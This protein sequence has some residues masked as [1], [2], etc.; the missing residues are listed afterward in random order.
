MLNLNIENSI[1]NHK[2]FPEN[3][4]SILEGMN[5]EERL[6]WLK[7]K[8]ESFIKSLLDNWIYNNNVSEKENNSDSIKKYTNEDFLIFIS[9]MK[10]EEFLEFLKKLPEE[11]TKNLLDDWYIKN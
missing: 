2:K 11:T 4:V 1:I 8:P 5:S 9:K 7:K 6:N 3:H 10:R